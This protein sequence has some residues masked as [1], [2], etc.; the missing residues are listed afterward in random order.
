MPFISW[1]MCVFLYVLAMIG[2]TGANIFYDAFLVDVTTDERTHK[3][4]AAGYAWG[5]IGSV[6]PFIVFIIPFA[7]V[8]LFGGEA[9]QLEIGGFTLTYRFS[10]TISMVCAVAWWFV[11]SRP[12]LKNV[13]Q[14]H[15]HE[16]VPHVIKESFHR[17]GDTF[18]NLSKNRNVF[19][20]CLAYFFYI[21]AVNTVISMAISLATDMGVSSVVSLA[22]VIF[23][24]VIA[25]PGAIIFG[26]LADRFG[27]KKMIL[28]A[29]GGYLLIVLVG[30]QL[31]KNVNLIWV[32][33]LLVGMFQGGIQAVSRSYFALLIPEKENTNEYF[34]FFEIFSKFAAIIGPVIISALTMAT[35]KPEIAILGL[36]PLMVFG[37]IFLLMVK[38]TEH[39]QNV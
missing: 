12:I 13:H 1:Q 34:G 15:Y 18:R 28:V 16:E 4:S 35:G 10:I 17:L 20:F 31:S 36:I 24:N 9:A 3:V 5:Y 38:D 33:G 37:A 32:V 27:G 11:Y 19:L 25:C 26:R 7:A 22:V 6:L 14:K 21:D 29:I 30:S 39:K 2:Y 8:T 23:I